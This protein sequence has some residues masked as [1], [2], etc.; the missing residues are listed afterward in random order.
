[1]PWL[2]PIRSLIVLALLSTLPLL[3]TPIAAQDETPPITPPP[4]EDATAAGQRVIELEA[5]AALLFTQDGEQLHDIP[6]TPGETVV[7]RINNTAGFAHNFYIGSDEELLVPAGQTDTGIPKWVR[8]GDTR[9]AE[10]EWTVPDD[11]ADLK[12]GCT[13]PGHYTLMQ[14]TFTVIGEPVESGQSGAV[15]V[16]PAA[17]CDAADANVMTCWSEALAR[18]TAKFAGQYQALIAARQVADR[19]GDDPTP[20]N[21]AVAQ[22]A[23]NVVLAVQALG[24]A[25]AFPIEME[26]FVTTH[27]AYAQYTRDT[28][29]LVFSERDPMETARYLLNSGTA[30][31]ALTQ[32]LA[33]A[34]E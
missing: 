25:D 16:E 29:G 31:I 22:W 15:R 27:A 10:L 18:T 13:V 19:A 26:E 20:T 5:T 11:I 17:P 23:D 3:A 8:N 24:V 1:M 9:V 6:V 30:Q 32:A 21:L 7:F 28:A 4:A 33:A 12:F 34:A 2:R 14:G